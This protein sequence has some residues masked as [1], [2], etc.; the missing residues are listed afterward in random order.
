MQTGSYEDKEGITRYTTDVI[1]DRVTF[2][3]GKK[4]DEDDG[5]KKYKKGRK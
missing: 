1:V 4:E 3:D 2:A 5:G